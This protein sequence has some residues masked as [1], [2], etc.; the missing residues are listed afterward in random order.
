MIA[1]LSIR[2]NSSDNH[3]W[4][5]IDFDAPGFTLED[6]YQNFTK[7]FEA[8][9]YLVYNDNYPREYNT[10][11][12][13]LSRDDYRKNLFSKGFGGGYEEI[14]KYRDSQITVKFS[15]K[16][17]ET[18]Q[19]MQSFISLYTADQKTQTI[20]YRDFYNM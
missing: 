19:S 16:Q 2:S 9:G 11:V 18:I 10:E 14:Y 17:I 5:H 12:G 20:D 4:K 8:C 3:G 15:K 13:R 1:T 7:K 6:I